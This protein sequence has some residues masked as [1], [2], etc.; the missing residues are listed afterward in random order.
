MVA[1]GNGESCAYRTRRGLSCAVGCLIPDAKYHRGIEG[2]DV[3]F[4][5]AED[6]DLLGFKVSPGKLVLLE[7][8]QDVHDEGYCFN[9]DES[10]LLDYWV[11]RLIRVAEAHGLKTTV[12]E[13]FN[14]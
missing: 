12:L 9:D 13:Q 8:L 1:T 11:S 6:K 5:L 7:A 14:D 2:K 10:M 3:R 4:I